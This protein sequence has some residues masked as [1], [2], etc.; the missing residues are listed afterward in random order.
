MP[1]QTALA[2]FNKK[3]RYH[4]DLTRDINFVSG[5]V[6]TYR[7][8][9]VIDQN[10]KDRILKNYLAEAKRYEAARQRMIIRSNA[11]LKDKKLQ[12]AVSE[13]ADAQGFLHGY[14]T[15]FELVAERDTKLES[16]KFDYKYE[17]LPYFGINAKE[18]SDL[19]KESLN[20]YS[21]LEGRRYQILDLKDINY[22]TL[23][24][25]LVSF[26]QVGDASKAWWEATDTLKE[27]MY[28]AYLTKEIMKE[29]LASKNWL[30]KLIFRGETNQMKDYIAKAE[31]ALGAVQW[32]QQAV[33]AAK[34]YGKSSYAMSDPE[35]AAAITSKL[36]GKLEKMDEKL[37][38]AI[39]KR[40]AEKAEWERKKLETARKELD[41]RK[42]AASKA[43]ARLETDEINSEVERVNGKEDLIERLFEIRF[44]PPFDK[45]EYEELR[46]LKNSFDKD[47]L[48]LAA[49]H[50]QRL[51]LKNNFEKLARMKD[52]FAKEENSTEEELE[53]MQDELTVNFL[54]DEE[55]IVK[56]IADSENYAPITTADYKKHAPVR[57]NT[58]IKAQLANDL[59]GA[60]PQEK[61]EP[62]V[63]DAPVKVPEI[64][65]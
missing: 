41:R 23:R 47:A 27:D 65:K 18:F 48:K 12:Q 33:D 55:F 5:V 34:E 32:D 63:N 51:V 44:R 1:Y 16:V 22:D 45:A 4:L 13:M 62:I 46:A 30:W 17:H 19:L 20:G 24:G 61:Q 50:D 58:E 10:V 35:Q 29:R 6:S 52:Y 25:E 15:T 26:K 21:Y 11:R 43:K 53:I 9:E 54:N 31:S 36:R 64:K 37:E 59:N 56:K 49:T 8:P 42:N 40:A 39:D 28:R 14:I 38:A 2:D 7:N 3:N 60:E 57:S